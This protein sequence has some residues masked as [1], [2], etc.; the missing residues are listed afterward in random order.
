MGRS[1][2]NI[3]PVPLSCPDSRPHL[4]DLALHRKTGSVTASVELYSVVK[5]SQRPESLTRHCSILADR[6]SSRF[7]QSYMCGVTI[8][9]TLRYPRA[10]FALIQPA[11]VVNAPKPSSSSHPHKRCARRSRPG[12]RQVSRCTGCSRLVGAGARR[13]SDPVALPCQ[14]RKSADIDSNPRG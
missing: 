10:A 3:R 9:R 5:I 14:R 4:A 1:Y 13:R 7:R 11:I 8:R 12:R 2:C 6:W